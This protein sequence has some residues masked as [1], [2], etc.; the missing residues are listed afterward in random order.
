MLPGRDGQLHDELLSGA[1]AEVLSLE[2]MVPKLEDE[3]RRVKAALGI[4]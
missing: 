1:R 2:R 4:S 3:L